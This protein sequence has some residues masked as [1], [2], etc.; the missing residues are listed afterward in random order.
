MIEHHP[1]PGA[2]EAQTDDCISLAAAEY[3]A[4]NAYSN[5]VK[6]SRDHFD[7]VMRMIK[8]RESQ[9]FQFRQTDGADV[10]HER[11]RIGNYTTLDEPSEKTR[12]V[13]NTM[14]ENHPMPFAYGARCGF[15][16]TDHDPELFAHWTLAE[17]DVFFAGYSHGRNQRL[18][19]PS[20]CEV[21]A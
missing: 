3:R 9:Q 15:Y 10:W 6:P 13:I 11:F 18:R 17:R 5:L 14:R 19:V 4:S 2:I 20:V 12:Q 21:A 1:A 16:C 7:R 8:A